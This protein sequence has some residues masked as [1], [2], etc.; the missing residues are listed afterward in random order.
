MRL[1]YDLLVEIGIN[2]N[3]ANAS[4]N[5]AYQTLVMLLVVSIH[6]F[7]LFHKKKKEIPKEERSYE[8]ISRLIDECFREKEIF[9]LFVVFHLVL[10]V[11]NYIFIIK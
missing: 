3:L 10:S 4:I 5:A 1:Y 2:E 9:V 6:K 11:A 7:Y 8:N